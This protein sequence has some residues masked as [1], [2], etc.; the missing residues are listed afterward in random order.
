MKVAPWST[1]ASRQGAFRRK[2]SEFRQAIT[3]DGP[4]AP[5]A[6]RYH[7]YV[8]YACPWAHRTLLARKLLGLEDAVTVDVVSWRMQGDGSWVFEPDEPG[9]T[10][11]S[12]GGAKSLQDVY[13][14]TCLLYTSP[15]PRD[16]T[17]SRM[18]S[19]A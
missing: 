11:D 4:F 2:Q 1:Q 6:G 5:E 15:S 14:R 9:C 18:P 17:R 7:L 10:A 13:K 3:E 12:Q 16:R 19:S 8:Q